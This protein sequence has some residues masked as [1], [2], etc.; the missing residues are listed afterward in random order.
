[1][2]TTQAIAHSISRHVQCLSHR[3]H[4]AARILSVGRHACNLLFDESSVVS[5]VDRRI[6]N[7]PFNV[8][9]DG[10][11]TL[12]ICAQTNPTLAFGRDWLCLGELCID[13]RQASVWDPCPDWSTLRRG[14]CKSQ[15]ALLVLHDLCA[16]HAC[17]SIFGPLLGIP[18]VDGGWA[19]AIPGRTQSAIHDLG[20]GWEGDR[21]RL[22]RGAA[23]LAGLG[24]GLTPSGDDLLAGA[25]LGAWLA[26]PSP[27]AFCGEVLRASA[28]RTTALSA[29]FLRAA[30]EGQ[31]SAPWHDLLAA[32]LAGDKTRVEGAG[33]EILRHGATSGADALIGFLVFSLEGGRL[34]H[35]MPRQ[36]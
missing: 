12:S 35:E 22:R 8:V 18:A 27:R 32:L 28:S 10:L 14:Y 17:D 11:D 6:G 36:A 16:R 1:M 15:P 5:L 25:M 21:S 31:C 4:P 34:G 9:L 33:R 24:I 7:G 20:A 29:A 2:V 3:R 19:K 13:L 23:A 26:H 30:A